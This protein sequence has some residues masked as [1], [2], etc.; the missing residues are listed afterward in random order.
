MNATFWIQES[1]TFD[2]DCRLPSHV[3][4]ALLEKITLGKVCRPFFNDG[5]MPVTISYSLKEQKLG[6]KRRVD[7]G[8]IEINHRLSEAKE[9][10][11]SLPMDS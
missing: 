3:F 10:N 11:T 2:L 8:G 6:L 5:E 9:S 7:E 1:D 4:V